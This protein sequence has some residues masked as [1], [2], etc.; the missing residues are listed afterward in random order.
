MLGIHYKLGYRLSVLFIPF[1][2]IFHN[3]FEVVTLFCKKPFYAIIN[4]IK[5]FTSS[6]YSE[7]FVNGFMLIHKCFI[8][9]VKPHRSHLLTMVVSF[10]QVF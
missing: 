6:E 9:S 8:I 4:I 7:P 5:L 2:Y 3:S 10:F 1:G